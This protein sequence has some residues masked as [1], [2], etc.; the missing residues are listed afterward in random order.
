[1]EPPS[2]NRVGTH[3]QGRHVHAVN[4]HENDFD[5]EE[6]ASTLCFPEA[7]PS[8]SSASLAEVAAWRAE[9][10]DDAAAW[11][12][13]Y[14][15]EANANPYRSR[16]YLIAEF[17][18]LLRP[19][20]GAPHGLS[21]WLPPW[22]TSA[23]PLLFDVGCGY[24]S[25]LMPLLRANPRLQAVAVDLSPTAVGRLKEHLNDRAL[26]PASD[27]RRVRARP[28]DI[29]KGLP[30][31]F[32]EA[33][34]AKGDAT[35]GDATKG[36]D[37]KG[38]GAELEHAD[39]ALLVFT[40]SAIDPSCHAAVLRRLRA[41]LRPGSGTILFRDRARYDLTMIRASED[42]RLGESTYAR[43]DG[44]LAHYFTAR[45]VELLAA[46]AG[47]EVVDA[48]G[49]A[50]EARYC[51]VRLRNRRKGTDMHR[52]FV[53]A[54]LRRPMRR[55]SPP[56]MPPA[57]GSARGLSSGRRLLLAVAAVVVASA[58]AGGVAGR[59]RRLTA[60]RR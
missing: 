60:A 45:E 22:L 47:L 42:Q 46:E 5:Y 28:W 56:A 10:G 11:D 25:A 48:H 49:D 52:C 37:A 18:E 54:R 9:N 29:T 24:G 8:S 17:P 41:A 58:A 43:E 32:R 40:L 21:S 51:T 34:A 26:F 6:Y 20:R 36:D 2:D 12:A 33:D 7:P 1:M 50:S 53:E 23:P 55:P 15:R 59:R 19:T 30:P 39:L 57:D 35:K 4:F 27:R 31:P 16:R 44:T 3:V 14:R 38:D 13:F